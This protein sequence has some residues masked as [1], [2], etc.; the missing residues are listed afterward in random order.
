MID[1]RSSLSLYKNDN[2]SLKLTYMMC[3]DVNT[4]M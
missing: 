1:I 2:G 4:M 3:N